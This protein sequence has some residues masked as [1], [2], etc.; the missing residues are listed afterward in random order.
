VFVPG[1]NVPIH[2]TSLRNATWSKGIIEIGESRIRT[3]SLRTNGADIFG[4]HHLSFICNLPSAGN[5]RI[6]IKGLA[7]PD[8]GIVQVYRYDRPV[9]E[10]VN[11][12]AEERKATD[13]LPLV[14]MNLEE[15]S[16]I[17][18]LT[19]IGKDDRSLGLNLDLVEI[20][21]ERIE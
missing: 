1:W 17:V 5:Y 16:N 3:L 18:F 10:Y 15:G 6:A 11:L 19:L 14:E 2:T 12:Y 8:Q 9:G 13:V 20:V 4:P 7:G 21:F